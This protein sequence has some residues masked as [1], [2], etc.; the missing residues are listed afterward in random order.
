MLTALAACCLLL[1]Q[2]PTPPPVDLLQ[3]EAM[4]AD[5]QTL[6]D[7]IRSQWSWLELRTQQGLDLDRI[8]AGAREQ[9]RAPLDRHDFARV[10]RRAVTALQDG[11]AHVLVPGERWPARRLP[12][13]LM[14]TAEGAAIATVEPN[15]AASDGELPA[16][17]D[18]LLRIGD[19]A[20]G[21]LI[22]ELLP[23]V[24]SSSPGMARRAALAQLPW[25]DAAQVTLELQ[26]P[27]G[28]RRRVTLRTA[29]G[30][31]PPRPEPAP[32]Q[33]NWALSFPRPDVALLRIASFSPPDWSVWARAD[34]ADR[35][36]LLAET[37]ALIGQ[38]FQ[39]IAAA[40]PRALILDLRG[41]GGGTDLLG[42]HLAKHLV[43]GRFTY[44]RLAARRNW[45][46]IEGWSRPGEHRYQAEADLAAFRGPVLAL[47][48]PGCFSVTDNLLRCLDDVHH[49]FTA[50]GR[51]SGAGTGAP[52]QLDPLPNSQAVVTFCTMRV[53]GPAGA[54][55][56]GSG[57][58]PDVPVAWTQADVAQARDPDLA[59]ALRWLDARAEADRGKEK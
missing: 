57:T 55:I 2:D 16:V 29:A 5:L 7:G 56:E 14:P 58:V 36:R 44:F 54:P 38:R 37:F 43:P 50:V 22:D 8:F 13:T 41:N 15:A 25:T 35:D 3:P 17:G 40:S 4:R 34:A 33:A 49:D 24:Y 11:H 47:I 27:A 31:L 52:R 48:D 18:L 30:V 23:E 53:Y 59:A 21:E 12:L 45:F 9:I 42:I 51:P 6:Q 32:A 1:P 28:A 39:A 20:V 10:L 26:D 46:G 19:R